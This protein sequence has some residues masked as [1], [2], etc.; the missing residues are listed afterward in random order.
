MIVFH[1]IEEKK[2]EEDGLRWKGEGKSQYVEARNLPC[3]ERGKRI[4]DRV[5]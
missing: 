4:C 3:R 1:S 2:N 5:I